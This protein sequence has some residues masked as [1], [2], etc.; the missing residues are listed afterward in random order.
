M[1]PHALRG[2]DHDPIE[3]NRETANDIMVEVCKSFRM[4]MEIN[5]IDKLAKRMVKIIDKAR[6][7]DDR[8]NR[9]TNVILAL[10]F[11]LGDE[12]IKKSGGEW[13]ENDEGEFLVVLKNVQTF[14]L[15]KVRKYIKNGEADSLLAF[16]K[17][18][19][20]FG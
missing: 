3:E 6:D 2:F 11:F 18:T 20:M 16:Y 19:T 8:L 12:L 10:G 13:I 4:K 5:N 17:V 1:L 14:P 7:V 9:E 15:E